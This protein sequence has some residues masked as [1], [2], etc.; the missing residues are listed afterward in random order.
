MDIKSTSLLFSFAVLLMVTFVSGNDCRT[1]RT[2]LAS[3]QSVDANSAE[4]GHIWQHVRGL[5]ARPRG[6][7]R[8]ETQLKK[9]LFASESD[10]KAACYATNAI[11]TRTRPHRAPLSSPARAAAR[12]RFKY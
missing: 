6:A 7:A 9:T 8:N 10:Y 1:S 2:V 5:H 11:L 3:A 12:G 4:G